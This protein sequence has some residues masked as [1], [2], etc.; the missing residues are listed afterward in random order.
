MLYLTAKKV[1]QVGDMEQPAP[2]RNVV[3]AVG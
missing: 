2:P 3:R 1:K